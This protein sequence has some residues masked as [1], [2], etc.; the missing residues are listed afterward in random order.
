MPKKIY[1]R[2]MY[3]CLMALLQIQGEE[4]EQDRA[5]KKIRSKINRL[6]FAL[7]Y[8]PYTKM[9]IRKLEHNGSMYTLVIQ[10]MLKNHTKKG[11]IEELS[12]VQKFFQAVRRLLI[13]LTHDE[14]EDFWLFD[15]DQIHTSS[16]RFRCEDDQEF[17]LWN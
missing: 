17:K 9:N 1:Y 13:K 5:V 6:P 2:R 16:D 8:V 15:V 3:P 4:P 14:S 10:F 7:S 12:H 11:A